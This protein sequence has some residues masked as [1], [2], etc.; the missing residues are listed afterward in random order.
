MGAAVD[1][2]AGRK[3]CLTI[4]PF[5]LHLTRPAEELNESMP[6]PENALYPGTASQ[7]PDARRDPMMSAARLEAALERIGRRIAAQQG[8][9][10]P[11][12]FRPGRTDPEIVARLDDLIGQ[13]RNA[14]L[15]F[16]E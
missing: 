14:L 13:I 2:D 5:V 11:K 4:K 12:T 9:A 7:E 15:S 16:P 6:L 1:H 8:D 10:E 3:M